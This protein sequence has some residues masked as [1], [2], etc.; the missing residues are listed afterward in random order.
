MKLFCRCN[1]MVDKVRALEDRIQ[2]LE[3]HNR[4]YTDDRYSLWSEAKSVP[5][6]S[7]VRRIANHLGMLVKYEYPK[8]ESFTT[9]FINKE[10]E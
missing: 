5:L 8:P 4:Y 10:K 1:K 9:E 3:I 6:S 7:V 2:M